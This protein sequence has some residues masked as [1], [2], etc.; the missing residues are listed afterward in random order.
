VWFASNDP[1]VVYSCAAGVAK[2]PQAH[3]VVTQVDCNEFYCEVVS[4][5]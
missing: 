2:D 3:I 1:C 4:R 5:Q